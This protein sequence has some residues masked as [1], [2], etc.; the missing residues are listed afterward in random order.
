MN[1]RIHATDTVWSRD[2]ILRRPL[3]LVVA[4]STPDYVK[5]LEF[6]DAPCVLVVAGST[7]DYVKASIL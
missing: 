3:C 2:G 1:P 7:P 4:G 6:L 5:A